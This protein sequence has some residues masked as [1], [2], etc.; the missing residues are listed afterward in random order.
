MHDGYEIFNKLKHF[1]EDTEF[2][3]LFKVF[4]EPLKNKRSNPS[5]VHRILTFCGVK[6]MR[7]YGK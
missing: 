6:T 5:P 7:E 3:E 4:K 2:P 1:G